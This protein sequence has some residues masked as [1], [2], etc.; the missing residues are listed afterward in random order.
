MMRPHID[1][2][3]AIRDVVD[4]LRRA[5]GDIRIGLKS[6]GE[7]EEARAL[8]ERAIDAISYADGTADANQLVRVERDHLRP[9]AQALSAYA[10]RYHIQV[11]QSPWPQHYP[12]ANAIAIIAGER[13]GAIAAAANAAQLSVL[14]PQQGRAPDEDLWRQIAASGTTVID[15]KLSEKKTRWPR[16][17]YAAGLA[18]AIGRNVLVITDCPADLPFDIFLTR[19]EHDPGR[20]AALAEALGRVACQV[21]VSHVVPKIAVEAAAFATRIDPPAEAWARHLAQRLADTTTTLYTD[22]IAIRRAAL[23]YFAHRP[24][25]PYGVEFSWFLPAYPDQNNPRCFHVETFDLIEWTSAAVKRG[26]EPH[27]M[28]ERGDTAPKLQIMNRIWEGIGRASLVAVDLTGLNPN[29]CLELAVSQVLGR[30]LILLQHEA[31]WQ[32]S[33]RNRFAEIARLSVS[34]YTDGDHLA[35]QVRAA[36]VSSDKTGMK[37]GLPV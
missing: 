23:G 15:L 16:I 21:P 22:P 6:D 4:A 3:E 10:R 26:C 31:S 12:D 35:A 32:E 24:G 19:Y 33:H 13:R 9:L 2:T 25:R 34:R 5:S 1:R 27:L 8:H 36:A 37:C 29:V 30:R 17:C 18:L 7:R 14:D 11:V 28:Y 20:A